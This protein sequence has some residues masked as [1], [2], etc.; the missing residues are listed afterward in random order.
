MTRHSTALQIAAALILTAGARFSEATPAVDSTKAAPWSAW[1]TPWAAVDQS[2]PL[3]Q[4]P[5]TTR[6]SS[7][8][9]PE[10]R[11]LLDEQ[12]QAGLLSLRFRP[13]C[14][15]TRKP[16]NPDTL[17]HTALRWLFANAKVDTACVPEGRS[18]CGP[19]SSW[20]LT[21]TIASQ[22][23]PG[24]PL[25]LS[26]DDEG[27]VSGL[28]PEVPRQDR[29][30]RAGSPRTPQVD[31]LE[32]PLFPQRVPGTRIPGGARGSQEKSKAR[33][34][35]Q[36]GGAELLCLEWE[37]TPPIELQQEMVKAADSYNI[38]CGGCM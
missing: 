15:F 30:S 5:H 37:A 19:S 4:D 34:R 6:R 29:W 35:A 22:G 32:T 27:W 1:G 23:K 10:M 21:G 12:A 24:T 9:S 13:G 8:F 26:M 31:P 3:G 7:R 17:S 28:T 20:I 36:V 38:S 33:A 16:E 14:T 25:Q 18:H 11:A 2:T